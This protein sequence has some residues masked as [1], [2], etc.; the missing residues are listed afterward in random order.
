[1]AEK[2][3]SLII[4]YFFVFYYYLLQIFDT[5]F[6]SVYEHFKPLH[7]CH[8]Y[9]LSPCLIHQAPSSYHLINKSSCFA[10]LIRF[11][12][13]TSSLFLTVRSNNKAKRDLVSYCSC[14]FIRIKCQDHRIALWDTV[15]HTELSGC[16]FWQMLHHSVTHAYRNLA[17]CALET[18]RMLLSFRNSCF[19]ILN[20]SKDKPSSPPTYSTL[21]K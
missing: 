14:S 17:Q 1:M 12:L 13:K 3:A 15:F 7:C 21:H 4:C 20:I 9:S 19:S 10:Y 11:R 18:H 6:F 5:V 16:T 8:I 2:K